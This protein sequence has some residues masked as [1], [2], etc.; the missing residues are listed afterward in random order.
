MP[1]QQSIYSKTESMLQC[2]SS[3]SAITLLQA[4]VRVERVQRDAG[5]VSVTPAGGPPARFDDLVFACGAEEALRMLG[6]DAD[7]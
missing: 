6:P 7:W 5:G 1:H 3:T 2:H 4:G